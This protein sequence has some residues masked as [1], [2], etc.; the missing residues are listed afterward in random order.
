ML[1]GN[2]A[3]AVC[4][5]YCAQISSDI[6]CRKNIR[7]P[8]DKQYFAGR[9]QLL[10]RVGL[11]IDSLRAVDYRFVYAHLHPSPA[12]GVVVHEVTRCNQLITPGLT[13]FTPSGLLMIPEV[14]HVVP[15]YHRLD[16]ASLDQS[17]LF[18]FIGMLLK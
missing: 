3:G 14:I 17:V 18:Y 13:A 11:N 9:Q 5:R 8:L 16:L 2:Q 12:L 6:V 10:A 7:F 1:C 15:K 4:D